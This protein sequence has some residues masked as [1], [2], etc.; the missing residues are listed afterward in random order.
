MRPARLPGR[1]PSGR[2]APMRRSLIAGLAVAVAVALGGGCVGPATAAAST[3]TGQAIFPLEGNSFSGVVAHFDLTTRV[4]NNTN[5][6][7][8][9]W[10]DRA[11]PTGGTVKEIRTHSYGV[12][13]TVHDGGGATS[14]AFTTV[15]ISL[16]GGSLAFASTRSGKS[17]IWTMRADG[18]GETQLTSNNAGEFF[19]P[20]WAPDGSRL[21]AGATVLGRQRPVALASLVVPPNILTVPEPGVWVLNSD[22]SGLSRLAVVQQPAQATPAWSR[23]TRRIAYVDRAPAPDI[24]AVPTGSVQFP[25]MLTQSKRNSGP[26]FSPN[27]DRIALARRPSP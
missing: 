23:G 7:T 4:P 16:P 13:I 12:K 22:G 21:A 15:A 8:I 2:S 27:G 3:G 5:P 25:A 9:D 17:E 20:S 10:G 19:S 1:G 11:N 18:G 24:F 26:D 14:F 6:L